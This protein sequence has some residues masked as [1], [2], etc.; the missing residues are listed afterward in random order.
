[1]ASSSL[2]CQICSKTFGKPLKLQRHLLKD[3]PLDISVMRDSTVPSNSDQNYSDAQRKAD[4]GV[5]EA[6]SEASAAIQAVANPAGVKCPKCPSQTRAKLFKNVVDLA[7]HMI[8]KHNIIPNDDTSEDDGAA[9]RNH[10]LRHTTTRSTTTVE[11][12]VSHK[13]GQ[14]RKLGETGPPEEPQGKRTRL[15][16]IDVTSDTAVAPATVPSGMVRDHVAKPEPVASP[17]TAAAAAPTKQAA[18]SAAPR[19]VKTTD[20]HVASSGGKPPVTPKRATDRAALMRSVDNAAQAVL[21]TQTAKVTTRPQQQRKTATPDAKT[22]PPLDDTPP[23]AEQGNGM[24][25]GF[26]MDFTDLCDLPSSVRRAYYRPIGAVD[27]CD[28][29]R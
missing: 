17:S 23:D 21:A 13:L 26:N 14:K 6:L 7:T 10:R 9:D 19:H 12:Q 4:E 1:M 11:S 8:S 16:G 22:D 24:T 2:V 5:Q 3:H 28:A 25:E 27:D 18:R 20:A 29:D 15:L